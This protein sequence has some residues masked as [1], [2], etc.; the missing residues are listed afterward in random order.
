V[1]PVLILEAG[2]VVE[3]HQYR[4]LNVIHT[5][6]TIA[7][8]MM[9]AWAADEIVVLDVS[10]SKQY[11]QNFY[12]AL[13]DIGR[14]AHCPITAGGWIDSVDE[15][16]KL[17]NLCADKV[18]INT[19]LARNPSVV[20]EIAMTWGQQAVVA[21]IDIKEGQWVVNRGSEVAGTVDDAVEAVKCYGAGEVFLTDINREGGQSGYD[22]DLIR[23]VVK[24]LSIPLIAFGGVAKHQHLK[25]G[26]DAGASGVAAANCLHYQ[27][28]SV[29]LAKQALRK[30]GCKVR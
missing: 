4:L 9:D 30:W 20:A 27:E 21:G 5:N 23:Y 1:I 28:R 25:D 13:K 6:P 11:R 22:L 17:F 26:I 14:V 2:Y 19:A 24:R 15:A 3:S 8:E 16:R 18:L 10:R 12:D 7:F 29:A